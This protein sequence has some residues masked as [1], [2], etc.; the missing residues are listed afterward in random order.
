MGL[1]TTVIVQLV[2]AA[3]FVPLHASL[4]IA[5]CADVTAESI[6]MFTALGFFTVTFLVTALVCPTTALPHDAVSGLTVS[7]NT[8]V[9]VAVG[10]LV[11]VAVV[12]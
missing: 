4:V 2:L 7:L 12:V 6:W 8:G 11:G 9:A 3:R 1:K 10:V 5:N